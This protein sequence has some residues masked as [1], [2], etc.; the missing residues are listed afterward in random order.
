MRWK[1]ERIRDIL[2]S[3]SSK[4]VEDTRRN[5]YVLLASGC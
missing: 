5:F 4:D 3:V 1:D 2:Q